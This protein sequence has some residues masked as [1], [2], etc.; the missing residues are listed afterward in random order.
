MEP[1]DRFN[2]SLEDGDIVVTLGRAFRAVY[3]KRA[4]FPRLILRQRTKS[5]DD[6]L[7]DAVWIAANDKARKLGWIV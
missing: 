6:E 2:V 4:G 7:L 3:Y 5:D 1:F